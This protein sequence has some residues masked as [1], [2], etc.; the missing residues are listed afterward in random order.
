MFMVAVHQA[1]EEWIINNCIFNKQGRLSKQGTAFCF[2][3]N[4]I[5]LIL[6]HI[7]STDWYGS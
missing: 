5:D 6:I 1:W 3:A 7:V 4:I 2:T